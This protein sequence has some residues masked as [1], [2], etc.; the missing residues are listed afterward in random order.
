MSKN[1]QKKSPS[2]KPLSAAK[3]RSV[4]KIFMNPVDE[5]DG[6]LRVL[7]SS[8]VPNISINSHLEPSDK[9]DFDKNDDQ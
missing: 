5:P 3:S 1:I 7:D 2:S 4:P 6:T 9:E 8:K